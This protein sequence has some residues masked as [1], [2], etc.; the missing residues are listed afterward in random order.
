MLGKASVAVGRR[1]EWGHHMLGKASVAVGRRGEWG[2]RMLANA[3]QGKGYIAQRDKGRLLDGGGGG[4][5]EE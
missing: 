3:W 5:L 2:H 1:G 4:G